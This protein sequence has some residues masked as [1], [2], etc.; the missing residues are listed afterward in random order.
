MVSNKNESTGLNRTSFKTI[1]NLPWQSNILYT[2]NKIINNLNQRAE[3]FSNI[4]V[5][6]SVPI[7][8]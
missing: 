2:S 6:G 5:H 8:L 3:F 4:L 7:H 1:H